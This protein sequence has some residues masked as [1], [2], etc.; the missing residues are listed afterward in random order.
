[1]NTILKSEWRTA[2][3]QHHDDGSE[4]IENYDIDREDLT[5]EEKEDLKFLRDRNY[6]IPVGEKYLYQVGVF[7]GDFYAVHVSGKAQNLIMKYELYDE[8]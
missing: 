8:C 1:M 4:N 5:I 6:I 2:T 3:K 7:D